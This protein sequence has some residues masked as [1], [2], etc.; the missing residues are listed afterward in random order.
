MADVDRGHDS[1]EAARQPY[2]DSTADDAPPFLKT[3][4]INMHSKHVGGASPKLERG[5][6]HVVDVPA[7]RVFE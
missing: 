3:E 5:A 2:G 1:H 7:S 6:A 4:R